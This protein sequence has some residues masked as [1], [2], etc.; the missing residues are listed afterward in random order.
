MGGNK[1]IAFL[2]SGNMA[3]A[4]VKGLLR[5]GVAAPGD[6]VCSDRSEERGALFTRS[7]TA[8]ASPAPTARRW[9]RPTS[10]C[11]R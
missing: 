2:G 7:V 5:A 10:W 3:E 8:C 1:T 4:L 11:C 6:I 9:R